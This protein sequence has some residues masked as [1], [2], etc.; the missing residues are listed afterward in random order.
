M[1]QFS[2]VLMILA[3][4]QVAS[5]VLQGVQVVAFHV[6]LAG[7]W[8]KI[9]VSC[10]VWSRFLAALSGVCYGIDQ[11]DSG[12]GSP[13]RERFSTTNRPTIPPLAARWEGVASYWGCS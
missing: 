3:H 10:W 1:A 6:F 4:S 12:L 9:W 13:R 2:G 8:A 7:N 5:E 11:A